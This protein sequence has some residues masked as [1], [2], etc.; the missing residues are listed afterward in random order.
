MKFTVLW[1]KEAE[2]R[3]TLMWLNATNRKEITEAANAI[4]KLLRIDPQNVG[5]SR[6]DGTRIVFVPPL[7]VL[8]H[9]NEQDRIVSVLTIWQ[10]QRRSA[11]S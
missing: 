3:L 2:K 6:P 10:F 11:S 8:F 7:R 5:E 1:A 9:V 4:E